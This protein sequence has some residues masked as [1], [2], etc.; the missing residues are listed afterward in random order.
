M[1]G[2]FNKANDKLTEAMLDTQLAKKINSGS[3]SG[4]GSG[5]IDH[6]ITFEDLSTGLANV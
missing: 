4:G 2:Y 5:T 6:P 1:S 3:G